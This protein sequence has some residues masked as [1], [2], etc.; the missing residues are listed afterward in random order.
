[1][2][3]D[4]VNDTHPVHRAAS[5]IFQ[6][7]PGLSSE[8]DRSSKESRIGCYF[9]LLLFFF[10][11]MISVNPSSDFSCKGHDDCDDVPSSFALPILTIVIIVILDDGTIILMLTTI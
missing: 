5:D 9:Q 8:Q 1:M 4:G 3:D 2:T 10:I 11:I 7:S 6:T